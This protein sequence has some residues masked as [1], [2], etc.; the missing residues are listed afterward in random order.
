MKKIK[1]EVPKKKFNAG[2][3]ARAKNKHF[4][5]GRIIKTKPTI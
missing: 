3:F 5:I 1:I 2:G 4:G